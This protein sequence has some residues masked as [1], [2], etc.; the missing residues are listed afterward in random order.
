M[1][2]NFFMSKAI[3]E[4]QQA[5]SIGEFPVGCV[6]VYEGRVLVSGARRHSGIDNQ[7]E[8]DHAE[9]LALRRLVDLGNK[10]DRERLTLFST[11]EPCL[12]CY[13][14][15]VLNGI[16]K[17]VYAYEDVFG[18]GTNIDLKRLNPFYRNIDI[19]VVGHVLRA[20]SL[21]L[22]KRYFSDPQNAYLKESLLAQHTLNE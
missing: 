2:Y 8:L 16:T 1:D 15:S 3:E 17:I 13:A 18:G 4:A 9:M 22:F 14:A 6:I 10:V 5:L 21:I 19:T 11:L 20:E 12:M 7:N